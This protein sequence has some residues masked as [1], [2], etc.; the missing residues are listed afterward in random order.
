MAHDAAMCR[1]VAILK[2]IRSIF[3]IATWQPLGAADARYR[4]VCFGEPV[5][6]IIGFATC[7]Q[8]LAGTRNCISV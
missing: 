3:V 5:K 4:L 2:N 7:A 1:C 6:L 8:V